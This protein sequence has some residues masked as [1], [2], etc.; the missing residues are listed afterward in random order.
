MCR[1][2][3]VTTFCKTNADLLLGEDWASS[4]MLSLISKNYLFPGW[5]FGTWLQSGGKGQ[6]FVP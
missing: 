6:T 4:V 5:D 1:L 2:L 3:E